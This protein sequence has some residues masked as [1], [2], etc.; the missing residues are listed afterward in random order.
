MPIKINCKVKN[1]EKIKDDIKQIKEG[2]EK[3]LKDTVNDMKSRAPSWVAAVVVETYNIKKSEITPQNKNGKPKKMA[4]S[5]T[6]KGETVETLQLIYTGRLLTPTHFSMKPKNR[7][8]AKDAGTGDKH[9]SPAPYTVSAE[10][11]KEQRKV[12]GSNVFLGT[13]KGGSDIPFQRVG[14]GRTPLQAIKTLS[15]PQMIDNETVKNKIRKKLDDG[16][17]KRLEHNINRQLGL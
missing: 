6:V 2:S 9:R 16:L 12:L 13:N 3:A 11:K 5:I 8:K 1:F 10:I 4:G 17:D 7:P 15:V 14:K